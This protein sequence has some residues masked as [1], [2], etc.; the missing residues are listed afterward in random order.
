M[1]RL[2]LDIGEVRVGLALSDPT[3]RVATPLKV[4]DARSL[5]ADP[6]ALRTLVEEYGVEELVVGLPVGL[7]GEEG[8]QAETVRRFAEK[9]SA[10]VGLPVTYQDERLSSAQ[11]RRSMREAGVNEKDGRGAVDMVAASILLQ[12]YLD[13]RDAPAS[14]RGSSRD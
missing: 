14:D 3:G 7:S 12:A 6:S 4:M 1:R 11:A 9:L 2:G 13:T 5:A 8:P 10:A